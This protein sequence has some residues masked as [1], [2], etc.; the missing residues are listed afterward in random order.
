MS[1]RTISAAAILS[2]IAAFGAAP[3]FAGCDLTDPACTAT[4]KGDD[5]TGGV[6]TKAA[7]KAVKE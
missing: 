1:F 2:A 4:E 3:A 5:K 6:T 7:E